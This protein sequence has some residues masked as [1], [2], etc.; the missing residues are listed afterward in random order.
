MPQVAHNGTDAR[1][2]GLG[3]LGCGAFGRFCLRAYARLPGVRLAAAA[4][5]RSPEARALCHELGMRVLGEYRDVI[6]DE[7]VDVV[8]VA[9]PPSSHRELAMAALDAGKHVLCEKPPALTADEAQELADAARRAGRFCAVNFVMR[10]APVSAA[11]RRILRDGPL[12]RPLAARVTNLGSDAGL[13]P[14]HWFWDKRLSGGIFVEHGVHFFD[15][16]GGWLG[17]GRVVSA[18]AADR[19]R[20]PVPEEAPTPE[21][22]VQCTVRHD[23]GALVSHYHGFDQIGPMD[24]CEH[25]IRCEMGDVRVEG[26]LPERLV[27]DAAVDEAGAERLAACCPD[28]HMETVASYAGG[29]AIRGRGRMH[30]VTRRVRLLWHP[31]TD[32]EALYADCLRSLLGEQLA[33]AADTSRDRLVTEPLG[34]AAVALA[35][36]AAR[37]AER[38]KTPTRASDA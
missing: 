14:D 15:L 11:V 17:A 38:A 23:S 5:A 25:V 4:R 1:P 12:G 3:L 22:R 26:W 27:V 8:H 24:R 34:P 29:P 6:R 21:D 28:G 9:T 7:E 18:A 33:W 31:T 16:Y 35:E 36:R 37:L 10:H 20:P 19:L 32:K 13:A 30:H 2:P